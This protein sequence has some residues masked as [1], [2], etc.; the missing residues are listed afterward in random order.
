MEPKSVYIPNPIIVNAELGERLATEL[1][2]AVLDIIADGMS[3][4]TFAELVREGAREMN[5]VLLGQSCE[6]LNGWATKQH[7][8]INALQ[9]MHYFVDLMQRGDDDKTDE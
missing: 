1:Y 7:A 4:L 9:K 2:E 5:A 3:V 8:F 6:G